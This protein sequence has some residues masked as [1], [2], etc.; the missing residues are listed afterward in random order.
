MLLINSGRLLV[1]TYGSPHTIWPL[2]MMSKTLKLFPHNLDWPSST[3]LSPNHITFLR[4]LARLEGAIPSRP[5]SPTG[6]QHSSV[7]SNLA[8]DPEYTQPDE[9]SETFQYHLK[10]KTVVREIKNIHPATKNVR[11]KGKEHPSSSAPEKGHVVSMQ[12]LDAAWKK[13]V[14]TGMSCAIVYLKMLLL[15]VILPVL[16]L[17]RCLAP[18]ISLSF[19]RLR[20]LLDAPFLTFLL[21]V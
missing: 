3:T 5:T 17:P 15:L 16:L 13:V 2:I 20:L 6:S 11:I 10:N 18:L 19:Y 9:F 14:E 12:L 8:Y 7:V 4:H 21:I 1:E